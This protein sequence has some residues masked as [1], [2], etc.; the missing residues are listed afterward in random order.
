MIPKDLNSLS[1][2]WLS[3][4]LRAPVIDFSV[5]DAHA[6]TTGRALLELQYGDAVDLPARLFVKLPPTDELQRQF[7]TSSGMG[8]REEIGR[9]HV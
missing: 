7:V 9:A 5:I 2:D 4:V 6:G 1:S 3:D 8:R